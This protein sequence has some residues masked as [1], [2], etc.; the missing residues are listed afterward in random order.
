MC[1]PPRYND[2]CNCKECTGK[3]NN[4]KDPPTTGRKIGPKFTCVGRMTEYRELAHV[5]GINYHKWNKEEA[6]MNN[7]INLP[8]TISTD[9]TDGS[10]FTVLSFSAS[11]L[12]AMWRVLDLLAIFGRDVFG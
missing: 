8:D 2:V 3:G 5:H 4:D 11:V 9:G 7:Y 1:F 10:D 12:L 6:E